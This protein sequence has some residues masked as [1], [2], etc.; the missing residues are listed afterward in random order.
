MKQFIDRIQEMETLTAEYNRE[1]SS[2]VILFSAI[3]FTPELE[4]YAKTRADVILLQ[5]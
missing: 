3:G 1:G 4:A 5:S 2:L